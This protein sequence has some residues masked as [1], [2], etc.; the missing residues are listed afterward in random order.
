MLPE[1]DMLT[2]AHKITT[3]EDL[4][5]FVECYDRAFGT[6]ALAL[7]FLE[8]CEEVFLFRDHEGTPVAG[9]TI[10][11]QQAYRTLAFIPDAFAAFYREKATGL[12]T[13][14]LG[15]IWV[16]ESR[17]NGREKLEMW[18]HIFGNML[19][20]ADTVMIGTAVSEEIYRFYLRYG[21]KVAYHGPM[22]VGDGKL[23]EGWIVYLDDITTSKV[24]EMY[25]QLSRR[26]GR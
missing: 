16:D 9:Y 4:K 26:L 25:E 12:Q 6:Q 19:S 21:V 8:G 11:T 20:R 24:P 2:T 15:T 3:P 7:E 17:R 13:Y 14:E 10:N 18:V 23:V 22:Q 5:T 1:S